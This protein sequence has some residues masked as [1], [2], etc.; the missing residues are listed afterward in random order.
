MEM[1]LKFCSVC[2]NCIFKGL[3]GFNGDFLELFVEFGF[4]IIEMFVYL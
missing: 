1:F 3:K 4:F 2:W